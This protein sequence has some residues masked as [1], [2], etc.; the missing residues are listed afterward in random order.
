MTLLV[1]GDGMATRQDV[2]P[3]YLHRENGRKYHEA[4]LAWVDHPGWPGRQYVVAT[5]G[6]RTRLMFER[7]KPE[8]VP[9]SSGK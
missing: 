4:E 5:T 6:K 1:K 3:T 9:H 7:D 8:E 2:G